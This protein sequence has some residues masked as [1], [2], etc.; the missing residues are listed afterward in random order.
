MTS[1]YTSFVLIIF[2]NTKKTGENRPGTGDIFSAIMASSLLQG[3]SLERSVKKASDFISCCIAIS[4][5]AG[6]PVNEGVIFEK[7]LDKLACTS[8]SI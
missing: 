6:V 7:I 8:Y 1:L 4:E 5:E 2:L 3:M